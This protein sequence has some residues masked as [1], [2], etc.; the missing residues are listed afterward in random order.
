[1]PVC[2]VCF[3]SPF[4]AACTTTPA[5]RYLSEQPVPYYGNDPPNVGRVP[6]NFYGYQTP[7]YPELPPQTEPPQCGYGYSLIGAACAATTQPPRP[8]P[9]PS[10]PGPAPLVPVDDTCG[11]WW[12]VNNLW[13]HKQ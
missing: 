8:S 13:C 5:P 6:R 2:I 12:R 9:L 4:V 10:V 1:M 7:H 3:A 11:D